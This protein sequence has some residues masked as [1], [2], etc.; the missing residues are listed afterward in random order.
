MPKAKIKNVLFG[1]QRQQLK[2]LSKTEYLSLRELCRLSKNMYNVALYQVRQYYFAEKKY[3]SYESNYHLCKD[4]ENYQFLNSNSAQQILKVVDRNF[5]SFFALIEKAKKGEYQ[6]KDIKLPNYLPKDGYFTL[7]FSEFNTKNDNFQV[8]MSPAFRKQYGKV[9]FDLPSNLK[10]KRIKEVRILPKSNA[11]YFE[12]QYVYEVDVIQN[13]NQSNRVLAID[14]GVDN[15][16]TCVTNQ[17]DSYIIDGKRL[18]SYNQWANKE[19]ARLQAIKDKQGIKGTTKAQQRLWNKRNHQ[20]RD[21][22]NKTSRTIL[23]YCLEHGIGQVIIGYNPTWQ[24]NSHLGKTNNQNFAQI[25]LGDIRTKLEWLCKQHNIHYIEQE[26]SYTS[27]AS[28]FDHDSIPVYKPFDKTHYTFIGN[29]IQRGL[30]QCND[31]FLVN[32]DVNGAFNIMRKAKIKNIVVDR[33]TVQ[34]KRILIA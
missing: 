21:Y 2:H 20:V 8:P 32:A 10:E 9:V 27:K 24:K 11:R 18:K 3:L 34:P 12:V 15:L 33:K 23:N 22:I 13:E 28:F 26:E 5:A 7:I 29:R 30:Y 16:A 19:N 17:G 6:F 1:V 14:L 31:G 4:N 25:P